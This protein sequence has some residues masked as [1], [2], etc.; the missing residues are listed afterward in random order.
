[1][2]N[3]EIRDHKELTLR[4]IRL[5][6]EKHRQE[7]E[8]RQEVRE[9]VK[10]FDHVSILKTYLHELAVDKE[11][12][13]DLARVGINMGAGFLIN[14]VLGRNGSIKGFL[15]SILLEKLSSLLT[16]STLSGIVSGISRMMRDSG[17]KEH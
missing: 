8:L 15:S 14:K 5:K 1:M 13:F 12:Q 4:I 7:E 11:V 9:L 6:A 16:G 2:E 10:S 3:A 17:T